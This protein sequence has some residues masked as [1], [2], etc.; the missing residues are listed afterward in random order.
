MFESMESRTDRHTLGAA[1]NKEGSLADK[2]LGDISKLLESVRHCGGLVEG[3]DEG[4]GE[5][6]RSS[7]STSWGRPGLFASLGAA[8]VTWR[9]MN[10]LDPSASSAI[11]N[12]PSRSP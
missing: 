4:E 2:V 3:I 11:P 6:G 9:P 5:G 12:H 1:A 8:H 10:S 7:V